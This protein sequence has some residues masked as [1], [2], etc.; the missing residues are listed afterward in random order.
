MYIYESTVVGDI[1]S[2]RAEIDSAVTGNIATSGLLILRKSAVIKDNITATSLSVEE[3]AL[4]EGQV[5]VSRSKP[6]TPTPT[7]TPTP[8][9]PTQE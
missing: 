7:S 1:V 5:I 8:S 6:T 4:L 3:N 2:Q 9:T